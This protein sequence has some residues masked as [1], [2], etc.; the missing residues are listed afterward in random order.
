MYLGYAAIARSASK[1]WSIVF[2]RLFRWTSETASLDF[3]HES[4]ARVHHDAA[5]PTIQR[6]RNRVHH[7]CQTAG[8]DDKWRLTILARETYGRT[9]SEAETASLFGSVNSA[10][11][12][13]RLAGIK[14]RR[15]FTAADK[16][17]WCNALAPFR[18]RDYQFTELGSTVVFPLQ[19]PFL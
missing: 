16:T 1:S 2:Y 9:N 6:T 11:C 14:G 19:Q 5:S 18:V 17:R 15:G 13:S 4:E 7:L 8:R 3:R 10:L 12:F